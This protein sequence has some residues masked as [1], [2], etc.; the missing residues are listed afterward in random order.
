MTPQQ[1]ATQLSEIATLLEVRGGS[2]PIV[3]AFSQSARA[4]LGLGNVDFVSLV[5]TGAM[6]Q[7]PGIDPAALSV[8]DDIAATGES[9]YLDNLRETTPEG[10]LEML[11]IPSLGPARIH[12]LHTGLGID[13]VPELEKAAR[14]G[15]LA[16]LPGFGSR[17]A[18][19]IL[20]GIAT[21]RESSGQLL[22]SLAIGEA[23]R[24][25][26]AI[27]S[28]PGVRSVKLAGSL[29]RSSELV[30]DIDLVAE[31]DDPPAAAAGLASLPGVVAVVGGGGTEL[32]LRL[33]NGIRADVICVTPTHAGVALW[34]A[35]GS[36]NHC[37]I[38]VDRLTDRGFTLRDHTL[39]DPQGQEVP[40]ADETAIYRAA[41]LPW[42][43]PEM[44]EARGEVDAA[45][46]GRLP[47]LLTLT[48]IRG[49]LHCHSSY[50]DGTNSVRTMAAAA[51][52]RGWTY[53]GVSDHSQSAAYA[54]GLDRD[55]V[56]RQHDEI[57]ELNQ[58]SPDFRIL[59]GIEADILADGSID[60]DEEFLS[61]FD[62]I[63]ASVHSRFSMDEAQMTA[64]MLR[65][66]DNPFVT[67]IG[68]PT[69]RLL[70]TREPYKV[71]V[72]ALLERAAAA[73]V[74]LELNCDPHRL[75]LD[76]RWLQVARARGVT[77]SM[78]PDAHSPD[79]LANIELGVG[80]ARKGWL[81]PD[82]ILNCG[83]AE[84]VVA[85]AR[86]RRLTGVN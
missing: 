23:N 5:R 60:Y 74:A 55:A 50:S 65:A 41:D 70:L 64:R 15:R 30:G 29:R 10:L 80:I 47:R 49:V 2:S 66:M 73:G 68:H 67:I 32:T 34:L 59:K 13:T 54:G 35:T 86:R 40:V 28:I 71:D 16:L 72:D 48:D 38:V 7:T 79:S 18:T 20:R 83:D 36:S 42:I 22:H 56:R 21:L 75:D 37:R 84:A 25:A 61:T 57:D 52:A 78:G 11:R 17:T 43:P 81:A 31:A 1:A 69:G 51:Q 82:D 3:Q 9:E 24:L 8:L 44:R 4:L 27:A 12:R 76:W 58:T 77:I 39:V 85:F 62:Y 26:S 6:A 19:R 45:A 63:I 33:D 14:D 53:M 46:S